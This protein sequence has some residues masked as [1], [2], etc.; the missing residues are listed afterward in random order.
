MTYKDILNEIFSQS[1]LPAEL[2]SSKHRWENGTLKETAIF[3]I[4]REHSDYEPFVGV[5]LKEKTTNHAND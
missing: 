5:K 4:I 3:R 2:K 1:P